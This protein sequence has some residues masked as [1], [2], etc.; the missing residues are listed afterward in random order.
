MPEFSRSVPDG[1]FMD[2]LG[3]GSTGARAA[4][5]MRPSD[6]TALFEHPEIDIARQPTA[7]RQTI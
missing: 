7:S 5:V 6:E 4:P 1:S 3:I 2:R